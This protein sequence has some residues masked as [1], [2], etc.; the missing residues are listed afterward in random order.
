MEHLQYTKTLHLTYFLIG[1]RNQ[2][3]R[4]T[5]AFKGKLFFI[6]SLSVLKVEEMCSRVQKLRK[7]A[8]DVGSIRKLRKQKLR[9]C[10]TT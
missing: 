7:C 6:R 3:T 4:Q 5:N 9:M 10:T 1:K 8:K 2:N